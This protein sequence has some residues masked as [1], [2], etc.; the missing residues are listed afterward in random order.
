MKN[1][2]RYEEVKSRNNKENTRLKLTKC[3]MDFVCIFHIC[4]H[5][6]WKLFGETVCFT[7][8]EENRSCARHVANMRKDEIYPWMKP[9]DRAWACIMRQLFWLTFRCLRLSGFEKFETRLYEWEKWL[10]WLRN[11]EEIPIFQSEAQESPFLTI[12]KQYVQYTCDPRI[13]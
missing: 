12:S 2:Y 3:D 13:L 10:L 5:E 6:R 9:D 4:W 1:Q 11:E 7:E 8:P